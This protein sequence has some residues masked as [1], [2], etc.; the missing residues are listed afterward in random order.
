MAKKL[1]QELIEEIRD[2]ASDAVRR[3]GIGLY[4]E[5]YFS[6]VY[7]IEGQLEGHPKSKKDKRVSL[8]LVDGQVQ[9]FCACL[10]ENAVCRHIVALC[11]F[12]LHSKVSNRSLSVA[13]RKDLEE[14]NDLVSNKD[15]VVFLDEMLKNQPAF[16]KLF[17][18]RFSPHKQSGVS[19]LS[20]R[21]MLRQLKEHI[22][23]LKPKLQLKQR[24]NFLGLKYYDQ[25]DA[26]KVLRAL[27][28]V[29]MPIAERFEQF[30]KERNY[31]GMVLCASVL[32]PDDDD[33]AQ[34]IRALFPKAT[35]R[36]LAPLE[37]IIE[38]CGIRMGEILSKQRF[39]EAELCELIDTIEE[40]AGVLARIWAFVLHNVKI[41]EAIALKMNDYFSYDLNYYDVHRELNAKVFNLAVAETDKEKLLLEIADSDPRKVWSYLL[42][43]H[44]QGKMELL[45]EYLDKAL[46]RMGL[47]LPVEVMELVSFDKWPFVYAK[48]FSWLTRR[49]LDESAESKLGEITE[50]TGFEYLLSRLNQRGRLIPMIPKDHLRSDELMAMALCFPEHDCLAQALTANLHIHTD[51]CLTIAQQEIDKIMSKPKPQSK[52]KRL[53]S[54]LRALHGAEASKVE[55]IR[56]SKQL[57]NRKDLG[58]EL[59]LALE[60]YSLV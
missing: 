56:I 39:D 19:F 30:A 44:Q 14:L 23:E 24:S 38:G 48:A 33:E 25:R 41:T 9:L 37:F 20:R 43:L 2:S 54:I 6:K 55:A 22:R 32:A 21:Q 50:F 28:P 35:S 3:E 8:D 7:Q 27:K 36:M 51:T 15:K 58:K 10:T 42:F 60:R 45:H 31:H 13:L 16:A 11:E 57:Y 5:G 40:Q 12:A 49:G 34:Q 17:V 52:A 26:D 59:K 18:Q 1:S 46:D 47:H 29:A 53:L 4:M